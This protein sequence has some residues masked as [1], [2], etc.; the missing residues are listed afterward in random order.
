MFRYWVWAFAISV[1]VASAVWRIRHRAQR[2]E[3]ER[4]LT[5]INEAEKHLRELGDDIG[6]DEVYALGC[7]IA[8]D[9]EARSND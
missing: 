1:I 9:W 4:M 5:Y 3:H 6:A 8:H 2:V 7:T